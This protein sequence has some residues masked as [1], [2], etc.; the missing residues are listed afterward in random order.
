MR[1]M[2]TVRI[3]YTALMLL[4]AVY[5]VLYAASSYRKLFDNDYNSRTRLLSGRNTRGTIYSADGYILAETQKDP[6]DGKDRR[7]YPFGNVFSHIIGFS[8]NGGSGIEDLQ[9]YYLV[10]SDIAVYH[11]ADYEKNGEKYPGNTVMTTLHAGL[12]CAAEEAMRGYRGA[13][14]ITEPSTGRILACVSKPDFDPNTIVRDWEEITADTASGQ[15]VNRAFQGAYP[16]GSTFK[17]IDAAAFLE[18]DAQAAADYGY[19]CTG[20][21]TAGDETIHCYGGEVHYDLDFTGSFVRSCNCSFAN[22]GLLLDRGKL[23]GMMNRMYFDRKLPFDMPASVSR[24]IPDRNCPDADMIQL[25]IGQGTAVMSPLHLNMITAAAA[26]GGIMM[27]PYAVD[28]VLTADGDDIR[29]F[30]PSEAGRVFSPE[31]ADA[32]TGMMAETV[33]SG[34]AR[35]LRSEAWTAA[36]KTGSAE[37]S[38]QEELSHAWFTGFAPAEDPQVCITVILEGAGSGSQ[39]AVPAARKVLDAWFDMQ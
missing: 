13:M 34:T 6:A 28:A 23:R 18:Q 35:G 30:H 29:V 5:L 3:F 22:I 36:G 17:I 33:Q 9:D 24:A 16:P 32:L 15:L 4:L 8:A 27:K 31:T 26:N 1:R 21:F 37:Y 2:K 39:A 7:V 38:E 19:T 25:S 10:R 11:K 20:T 12:Q 14:I